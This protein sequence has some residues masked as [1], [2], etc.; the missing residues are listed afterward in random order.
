[1]SN[2][3]PP[4]GPRSEPNSELSLVSKEVVRELVDAYWPTAVVHT[5]LPPGKVQQCTL[6]PAGAAEWRMINYAGLDDFGPGVMAKRN[7]ERGWLS[8]LMQHVREE[9]RVDRTRGQA[10]GE[11][12]DRLSAEVM[13]F[14][15]TTQRKQK[16]VARQVR[17]G[18]LRKETVTSTVSTE[19]REPVMVYNHRLGQEEEAMTVVYAFA[20]KDNS[21]YRPYNSEAADQAYRDYSRRT[22]NTLTAEMQLPASEADRLQMLV[23]REPALARYYAEVIT[24]GVLSD[25]GGDS[26]AFWAIGPDG[27][28]PV[29]PPYEA[30][31]LQCE[32][33]ETLRRGFNLSI[34]TQYPPEEGESITGFEP[35][36]IHNELVAA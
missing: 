15:P 27:I 17:T 22:G 6:S 11:G 4:G 1:M 23:E 14:L 8:R 26:V 34:V 25:S 16:E 33:D 13:A 35:L 5:S 19:E 10:V 32:Q 9:D 21:G 24:M 7:R 3:L 29:R 30:E 36:I 18:L 28:H 20:W 31:E 2:T 12:N